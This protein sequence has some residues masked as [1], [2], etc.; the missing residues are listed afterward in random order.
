MHDPKLITALQYLNH[1]M[2][3]Y[4][5]RVPLKQANMFIAGGCWRDKKNNKP[6]KDIDVY[7]S[8]VWEAA[9]N[10]YK[11][12]NPNITWMCNGTGSGDFAKIL[13]PTDNSCYPINFIQTKHTK[14]SDLLDTFDINICKLGLSLHADDT[15]ARY[16]EHEDYVKGIQDE[17]I[18]VECSSKV[19]VI[20]HDHIKR[21]KDK[22]PW[23][24]EIVY[25]D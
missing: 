25:Y 7:V 13:T 4:K 22:Y 12:T 5:T 19:P 1:A 20:K 14:L 16:I 6:I 8:D 9:R 11:A 21:V 23:P 3:T 24:V 18:R 15:P 17:V 2:N 10:L